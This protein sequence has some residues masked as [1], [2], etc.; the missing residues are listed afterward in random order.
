MTGVQTCALPISAGV[1]RAALNGGGA[2]HAVRLSAPF[3]PVYVSGRLT[4]PGAHPPRAVAVAIN[5]RIAATSPTYRVHRGGPLYFGA[6]V[7]ESALQEGRNE[8]RA[9]SVT[10]PAGSPRLRAL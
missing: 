6:I 8:V 1:T 3:V 9:F 2:F 5:G 7:P 10:G 4:R